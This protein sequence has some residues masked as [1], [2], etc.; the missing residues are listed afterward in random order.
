MVRAVGITLSCAS[1]GRARS[2]RACTCRARRARTCRARRART[3][4]AR[5]ARGARSC[6]ARAHRLQRGFP[7][8]SESVVTSY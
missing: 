4:R 2:R 3:C 7:P 8:H 1:G 5:G 6:R